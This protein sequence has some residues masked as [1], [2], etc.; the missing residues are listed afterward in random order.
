MSPAIVFWTW[1]ME[2]HRSVRD[3]ALKFVFFI[4]DWGNKDWTHN[5]MVITA[6]VPCQKP[7][8]SKLKLLGEKKW[9]NWY[10]KPII[11]RVYHSIP[12][13]L[14]SLQQACL[15][16]INKNCAWLLLGLHRRM[17]FSWP[18]VRLNA[19]QNLLCTPCR[20]L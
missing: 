3:L 7:A 4:E 18:Y 15:R 19:T 13:I 17:Y 9:T 12:N 2:L 5:Y 14:C 8:T 20:V 6:S 11:E 16:N 10:L 1:S